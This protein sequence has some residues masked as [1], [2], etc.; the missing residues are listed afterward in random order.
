MPHSG[1]GRIYQ[2]GSVW[3]IQYGHRGRNYRE[4][5]KSSKKKVAAAL[6]KKR[7]AEIGQGKLIGAS[8]ERITFEDLSRMISDDYAAQR[9]RATKQLDSTLKRLARRFA[10][11]RAVDITTDSLT[12]YIRDRQDEGYAAGTIRKDMAAIKRSF[13]LAIRAGH[14][15]VMP[16]IP[17]VRVQDA[18]EGFFTMA[19]VDAV[20]REIGE[21]LAPV[22]RFAALTGWRKR[23]VLGLTWPFVDFDAGTVH[24]E[25]ARSKNAEGRTFP[26][27]ALPQLAQLLHEQHERTHKVERE[28]KQIV[29]WVFHRD[30]EPILSMRSAW[31]AACERA[32]LPGAWFHDLRRTAVMHLERAGVSRSVAMKLTGHKTEAVYRRYAIAD[33][34]ALSEGVEKLARLHSAKQEPSKVVAMQR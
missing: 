3:W 9:R 21:D 33:A 5:S 23:E 11:F 1:L 20:A 13:R 24:L 22:V 28:S 17:N 27:S 6:L 32:G 12:T 15:A 30:G 25:A 26:F 8:A 4:S 34:A 7:M 31:D 16:Y 14:L 19:E 18:R 2:R 10:G 29:P